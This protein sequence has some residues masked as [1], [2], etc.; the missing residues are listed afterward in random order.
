M[1]SVDGVLEGVDAHVVY[2]KKQIK[3]GRY[4]YAFKDARKAS[5]EENTYLANAK[6]KNTFS[7]EQYAKKKKP[8]RRDRA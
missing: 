3:G 8:L 4:Q 2:K 1:L 7:A 5:K 6:R